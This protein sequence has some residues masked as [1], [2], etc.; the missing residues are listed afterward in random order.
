M[1]PTLFDVT[2]MLT[3]FLL[4]YRW[5]QYFW[6]K[7]CLASVFIWCVLSVSFCVCIHK[8]D[9]SVVFWFYITIIRLWCQGLRADLCHPHV[10]LCARGPVI[11]SF[12][13]PHLWSEN[14]GDTSQ[15][16]SEDQRADVHKAHSMA[17][18]AHNIRKCFL[19]GDEKF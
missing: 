14:P 15:A 6:N 11:F 18:S 3:D 4:L 2:L 7:P 9:C 17:D 16:C 5:L 12:R 13:L 10:C 1:F 8:G 19:S